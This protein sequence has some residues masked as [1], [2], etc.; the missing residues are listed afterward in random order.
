[1]TKTV[2]PTPAPPN[3]PILPPRGNGLEDPMLLYLFPEQWTQEEPQ[4][5]AVER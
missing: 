4:S 1:M 3:K 5:P 2:L